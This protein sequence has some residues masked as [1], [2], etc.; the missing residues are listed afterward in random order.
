[1]IVYGV[2]AVPFGEFDPDEFTPMAMFAEAPDTFVTWAVDPTDDD[3]DL[4]RWQD[5][6]HRVAAFR[7]RDDAETYVELC[8]GVRPAP[9]EK[10]R[11]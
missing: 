2:W 11:A 7:S 1:V 8:A 9:A 3:T 4:V 6:T 10:S 5:D